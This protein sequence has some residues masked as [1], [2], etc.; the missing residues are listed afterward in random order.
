V[1]KVGFEPGVKSELLRVAMMWKM[2]W[3]NP[4]GGESWQ[5]W[6]GWPNK[7]GSWF[8]RPDKWFV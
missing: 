4:R 3:K 6:W 1:E 8:Q 5:D 2:T 7:Y